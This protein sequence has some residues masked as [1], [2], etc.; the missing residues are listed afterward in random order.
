MIII[1]YE[2][3]DNMFPQ[4]L[5]EL[6]KSKK[7][8][9]KEFGKK[10]NLAESTIS[11]YEK[12]SRKPDLSL[13]EQFANFFDVST[14]YLLGRSDNADSSANVNVNTNIVKNTDDSR[15]ATKEDIERLFAN[16]PK[17]R[18]IMLEL[19]DSPPEV[20]EAFQVLLKEYKNKLSK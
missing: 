20:V 19:L 15:P 13:I 16:E 11:G 18:D 4:R 17:Y 2:G 12:G 1:S 9:M 10:F 3:G 6:R 8:T 14:D 7:L 5:R